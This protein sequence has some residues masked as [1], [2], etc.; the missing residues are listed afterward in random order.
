ALAPLL[1]NDE[2]TRATKFAQGLPDHAARASAL[3]AIA[4]HV[5]PMASGLLHEALLAAKA[6]DDGGVQAEILALVVPSLP[7]AEK[8]AAILEAAKAAHSTDPE[9]RIES[10]LVVAKV[11]EGEVR[12]K[13]IQEA[14]ELADGIVEPKDRVEALCA[15]APLLEAGEASAALKDARASADLIEDPSERVRL[16]SEICSLT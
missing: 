2:L 5:P 4:Q 11:A 8:E 1:P 7:A 15:L 12:Q 10:L 16:L 3:L 6:V 9:D 14:Q 13:L